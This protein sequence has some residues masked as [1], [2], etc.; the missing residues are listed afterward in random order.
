M[1]HTL[2]IRVAHIAEVLSHVDGTNILGRKRFP[3]EG[4]LG[5]HVL[6]DSGKH[7][8]IINIFEYL[9]FAGL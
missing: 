3:L 2:T 9:T 8:K 6:K 5:L 4:H 7:V 1:A